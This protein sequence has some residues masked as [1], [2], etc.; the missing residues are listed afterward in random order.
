MKGI[1]KESFI[2]VVNHLWPEFSGTMTISTCFALM[3]LLELKKNSKI[4]IS[5][6][7]SRFLSTSGFSKCVEVC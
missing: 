7:T 2:T 6:A 1:D 5:S 4:F 3:M